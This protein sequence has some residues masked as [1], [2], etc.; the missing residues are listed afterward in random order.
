MFTL[1]DR[2]T[3]GVIDGVTVG[4]PCCRVH[5]CKNTLKH[6]HHRFCP[7]HNAMQH[8]CRVGGCTCI[9]EA[10]FKTCVFPAHWALE[11][12]ARPS[13][14]QL[15][16][17]LYSLEVPEVVCAGTGRPPAP[18]I[19]AHEL[20]PTAGPSTAPTLKPGLS[21]KIKPQ[22]GHLWTHNEQLFVR[23]CGIIT[24]RATFYGSEGIAGV[25]VCPLNVG[26]FMLRL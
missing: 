15:R 21:T 6:H 26:V 16:S 18:G 5:N 22:F 14:S 3:A 7:E 1:I 17:R 19:D 25:K 9:V 20:P 8:N 23:C 12:Q 11:T 24:S 13:L 10:R 2:M 4:H